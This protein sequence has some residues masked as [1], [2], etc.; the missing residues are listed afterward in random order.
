MSVKWGEHQAKRVET[1]FYHWLRKA[2]Q[3]GKY[4]FS[5]SD[6]LHRSTS[7]PP[8]QRNANSL[9]LS[10]SLRLQTTSLAPSID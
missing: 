1:K 9:S 5:E 3:K 7:S 2:D 8:E 4:D 10:L 6:H